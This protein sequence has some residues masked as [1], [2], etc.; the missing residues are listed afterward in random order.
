MDTDKTKNW[1]DQFKENPDRTV[2]ASTDERKKLMAEFTPKI[3]VTQI[4]ACYW[5]ERLMDTGTNWEQMLI[6]TKAELTWMCLV[7]PIVW[8]QEVGQMRAAIAACYERGKTGEGDSGE[9][10][11]TIGGENERDKQ[12]PEVSE[13]E[14]LVDT[15]EDLSV[16]MNEANT[17]HEEITEYALDERKKVNR[18]W[19]RFFLPKLQRLK[20][21]L[22]REFV[23]NAEL[24]GIIKGLTHEETSTAPEKAKL[25]PVSFAEILKEQRKEPRSALVKDKRVLQKKTVILYPSDA[26]QKSETTRDA[27][28]TLDP[29]KERLRVKNIRPVGKGGVLIEA[30]D[31]ETLTKLRNAAKLKDLG[32]RV[33]APKLRGPKVILYD[34]PRDCDDEGFVSKLVGQN[35]ADSQMTV[36]QFQSEVVIRA[37]TGP[38]S[39]TQKVNLILEVSSRVRRLLVDRERIYL[40][41]NCCRARDYVVPLRCFKCLQFG[42]TKRYCKGLMTCGHCASTGHKF[43]ECVKKGDTIKCVNCVLDKRSETDHRVDSPDCPM[44][45]KALAREIDRID[46]G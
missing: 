5:A 46:Y 8:M 37:R 19:C 45:Q 33:E 24:K 27:L 23:R 15:E 36:E 25:T 20:V 1:Y 11:S 29:V 43:S 13:V 4:K 18:E 41:F 3:G 32:I 17:L 12:E 26:D 40:G 31:E 35:F 7:Y 42:H 9:G 22:D 30:A 10:S 14:R 39:N 34:V 28:K 38:R 2:T 21:L 16:I 6:P 44:Y